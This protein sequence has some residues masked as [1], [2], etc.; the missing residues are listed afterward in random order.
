[1]CYPCSCFR[2]KKK[3]RLLFSHLTDIGGAA[4]A[5]PTARVKH[6]ASARPAG[7]DAATTTTVTTTPMTPITTI[8]TDTGAGDTSTEPASVYIQSK[9]LN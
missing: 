8:D 1:M 3:K 5:H 9:V 7:T 6:P 2:S 4:D